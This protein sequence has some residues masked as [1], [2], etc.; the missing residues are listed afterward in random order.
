VVCARVSMSAVRAA[1]LLYFGGAVVALWRT[2]ASW[3]V[4]ILLALLWPI[5]PAAFIAA[6]ALLLGASVIA[7][8]LVG[9]I[10]AASAL[11]WWW[12]G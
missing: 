8:P 6:V 7:F 1:L 5:G 2:D 10:V 4:R 9:A 11:V 12:F 3:P